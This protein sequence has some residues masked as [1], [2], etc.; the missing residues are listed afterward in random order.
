MTF[1]CSESSSKKICETHP[2]AEMLEGAQVCW[3][4]PGWDPLWGEDPLSSMTVGP[5]TAGD[6]MPRDSVGKSWLH[7]VSVKFQRAVP[8]SHH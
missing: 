7:Q 4:M 8:S 5:G 6:L 2:E 3:P 1:F